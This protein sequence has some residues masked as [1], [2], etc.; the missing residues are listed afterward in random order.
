MFHTNTPSGISWYRPKGGD[1]LR[2]GSKGRYMVR[3]WVVGGCVIPCYT[4]VISERFRD[5]LGIIKR[6][7]NG[8][9]T[10]LT[11]VYTKII[12]LNAYRLVLRHNIRT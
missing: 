12:V 9:L 2:L 10:L 6:Y 4:Q 8:L 1:A 11:L 7:R 5:Q 3:V